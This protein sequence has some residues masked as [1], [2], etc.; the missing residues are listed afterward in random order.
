MQG[1]FKR[2]SLRIF[3]LESGISSNFTIAATVSTSAGIIT[4]KGMFYNGVKQ[5]FLESD[6]FD[7]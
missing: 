2:F 6:T 7:F 3:E 4:F 5:L 1:T